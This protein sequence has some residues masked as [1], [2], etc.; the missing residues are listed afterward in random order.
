MNES[1]NQFVDSN[2]TVIALRR[3][4]YMSLNIKTVE[5]NQPTEPQN[6]PYQ[7]YY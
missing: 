7:Y 1:I 5:D 2:N 4:A 6:N 3:N